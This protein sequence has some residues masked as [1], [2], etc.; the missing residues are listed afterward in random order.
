MDT[1]NFHYDLMHLFSLRA[2]VCFFTHEGFDTDFC[3]LYLHW[4]WSIHWEQKVRGSRIGK[5]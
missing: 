5:D 2:Q 4:P 3:E 1:D